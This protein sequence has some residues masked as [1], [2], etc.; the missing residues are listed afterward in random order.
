MLI[1]G[2]F[3]AT[4]HFDLHRLPELFCGFDRKPGQ[5]PT[6]YPSACAP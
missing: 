3:N 4:I 6:H 2:L 5:A 1:E